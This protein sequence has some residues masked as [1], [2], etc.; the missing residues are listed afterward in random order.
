MRRSGLIVCALV[1]AG[2]LVTYERAASAAEHAHGAR[3]VVDVRGERDGGC[4]TE[5]AAF[6][7]EV[8]AG[9]KSDGRTVASRL[10]Q[11]TPLLEM[12]EQSTVHLV[13]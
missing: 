3:W 7:H 6:E 11:V 9:C 10:Q 12:L 13:S 8:E 4:M 2:T 5:R 1:G